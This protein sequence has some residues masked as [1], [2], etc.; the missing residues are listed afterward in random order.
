MPW[1]EFT[2]TNAEKFS[3]GEKSTDRL[4]VTKSLPL[5]AEEYMIRIEL[6]SNKDKGY[7]I[8]AIKTNKKYYVFKCGSTA[9][10][11]DIP[12]RSGGAKKDLIIGFAGN[13]QPSGEGP[14]F[15]NLQALHLKLN[16]FADEPAELQLNQ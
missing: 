8:T 6:S 12:V 15:S 2:F 11:L 13:V 7:T 16:A 3:Q 4:A 14:Y 1:F 5:S 10:A 9:V